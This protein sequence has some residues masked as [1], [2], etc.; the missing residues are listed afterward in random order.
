MSLTIEV[1]LLRGV[2]E[3]V[4]P[5]GE[6]AEWPPHPAR[7]FCALVAAAGDNVAERAALQWLERELPPAVVATADV[8]MGGDR[9][10]YVPTNQLVRKPSAYQSFPA[11][12]ALGPKVWR[13]AVPANPMVAF[14]WVAD[15]PPDVRDSL[16]ATARRIGYLGRSTSPVVAE[17]VRW[18]SE[19]L[20]QD[21]WEPQTSGSDGSDIVLTVPR[22]GYLAALDDAF[23]GEDQPSPGLRSYVP[24]RR[25]GGLPAPR[26][27]VTH[28]PYSR[29]E[30]IIVGVKH[31]RIDAGF[32]MAVTIA[33]RN[34]I[35]SH[36]DGGPLVLRGRRPSEPGPTHQISCLALPFV[37]EPH[38]DGGIQGL[39]LAIP[40]GIASEDRRAVLVALTR[41]TSVTLGRLGVI[42]LDLTP[43]A[44]ATLRRATW[45]A[46]ARA[47]VTATPISANRHL[48]RPR[49]E[50]LVD[51]VLRACSHGGLPRPVEVEVA[52]TPLIP[53]A[54][55]IRPNLRVRHRGDRATPS[56]HARLRFAEPVAG[57]IVLGNLRHYGLGLMRPAGAA[58]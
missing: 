57:P 28:T 15:P 22:P 14:E 45:V 24:Y 9:P 55:T 13:R 43:Q 30:L 51:E 27:V 58:S 31:R 23:D 37:G 53:G 18:P 41:T 49:E 33:F 40:E 47:W 10:T 25:V 29:G 35:E 7:L 6:N 11:R 46:P 2:Y 56:F 21:R 50:D 44:K 52:K 8:A 36:I 12:K 1:E 3:A 17:V 19:R 39:A 54:P 26:D 34:A 5:D 20:P 38:G 48:R 42:E 32:T 16:R 4:A